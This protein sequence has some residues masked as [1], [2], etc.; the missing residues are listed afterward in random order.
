MVKGCS[1]RPGF[2]YNE[3]YSPAVWYATVQYLITLAVRYNLDIDQVDTVTAF[4][5]GEEIYLLQTMK[6]LL[7][8]IKV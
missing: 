5:Q 3:V 2:D 4:L 1:Q 8:R 6:D 7:R